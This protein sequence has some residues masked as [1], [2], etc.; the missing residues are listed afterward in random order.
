MRLANY[1]SCLPGLHVCKKKRLRPAAEHLPFDASVHIQKTTKNCF[2]FNVFVQD[3]RSVDFVNSLLAK[4]SKMSIFQKKFIAQTKSLSRE[5]ISI[6]FQ[7]FFK[8]SLNFSLETR[9]Y[10]CIEL[11]KKYASDVSNVCIKIQSNNNKFLEMT[12][13]PL[14]IINSCMSFYTIAYL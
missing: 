13:C 4:L 3:F 2:C 14:S 10:I 9:N 7:F 12:F 1:K 6:F 11:A 5:S 8:Y